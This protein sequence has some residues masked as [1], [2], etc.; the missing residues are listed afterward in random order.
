M[1]HD[2]D[3]EQGLRNLEEIL[4]RLDN[5]VKDAQWVKENAPPE[6]PARIKEAIIENFPQPKAVPPPAEPPAPEPAPAPEVTPAPEPAP[7]PAPA[8]ATA[9]LPAY[10]PLPQPVLPPVE[11]PPL[12]SAPK[13]APEPEPAPMPKLVSPPALPEIKDLPVFLQQPGPEPRPALL[14]PAPE[15]LPTPAPKPARKPFAINKTAVIILCAVLASSGAAYQLFINSAAQRYK[16]AGRL[17]ERARNTEAISAY[18]RIITRYPRSIEAAY[19]HYG[20]GD[21]KALQGDS[22]GAIAS[23]ED[24][25]VAAPDKDPKLASARFKVAELHFKEDRLADADY[26]YQ[27]PV[28]RESDLAGRA[29]ERVKEIAAVNARLAEAKKLIAKAPNKAV[30]AYS[31]VVAERPKYAAAL[32]GLEEARAALAAYNGRPVAKRPAAKKPA[33]TLTKSALKAALTKADSPA[34]KP[35]QKAAPKPAAE[36]KPAAAPSPK[37]QFETCSAIWDAE[38]AQPQLSADQIFTKM[39][40]RCDDLKQRLDACREAREDVMALQGVP[41]EARVAMEL[42]IDPDWTLAKQLEQDKKIMQ[43]YEDR[44][45]A[46]LLKTFPI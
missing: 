8:P 37:A 25:M 35:A 13:P 44:R 28:V 24:Y 19:S 21:I 45:C 40:L 16:Q 2:E 12:V 36:Q 38:K 1:A 41:P 22:Q 39:K 20:I 33:P 15:P 17:V 46:E 10:A 32:A 9:M 5:R 42:E 27:N 18:S 3:L 30:E 43:R 6:A 31:A 7:A 4:Q 29:E 11:I 23:Y 14:E 34:P 26:L